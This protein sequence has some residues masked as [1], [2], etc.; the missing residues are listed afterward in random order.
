MAVRFQ[1]FNP[2]AILTTWGWN[3][4]K[5]PMLELPDYV[6]KV[7]S[8][9]REYFYFRRGEQ[10]TSLPRDPH[11]PEFYRAYLEVLGEE[12][13]QAKRVKELVLAYKNSNEFDK[14]AEAT[15]LDY[16]RYLLLIETAWGDLLASGVRP[17]HALNLRDAFAE[18]ATKAD[19][20]VSIGKTLFNWGIPREYSEI[21]PFQQIGRIA[22]E[23]DG[24]K[25]WPLWAYPLI[26][27]HAREDMRRAV[28]L[29]RYTGQR[30]KDVVEMSEE[31]LNDGGIFVR[32]SK[33]KKALWIPLHKE[34]KTELAKWNVSGPI[35]QT[36]KRQ[37]Y[38]PQR[39]RAAWSRLMQGPAG[40]IR[41][42][43]FTFHGLRASSVE[44]LREVGCEYS[45][46]ESITGMSAGMVRR[47]SRFADQKRI[48]LAAMKRLEERGQTN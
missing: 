16:T 41:T 22:P 33:T 42:E 2:R 36:P 9:S 5:R 26:E 8:G 28:W 46:I 32:Q 29:A 47:Y 23:S 35:V 40:Q 44:K 37:P 48:A 21:N 1:W 38:T 11:S 13:P 19:H 30:Q 3:V 4:R 27:T 31:A 7:V 6:Q 39:F 43:G 17:K 18:K 34:L 45:E 20:L 10:R 15:K 24:A 14:L 12:V 25:P